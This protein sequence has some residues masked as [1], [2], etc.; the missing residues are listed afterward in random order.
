[1]K[2][3]KAPNLTDREDDVGEGV[4]VTTV[5][6][7][8]PQAFADEPAHPKAG[9]RRARAEQRSRNTNNTTNTSSWILPFG[10][11]MVLVLIGSYLLVSQHETNLVQH[12]KRNE[13]VHE[14]EMSQKFDVMYSD[15][16]KENSKLK[17]EI[18][19]YQELLQQNEKLIDEKKHFQSKQQNL[20]KQ[21]DYLT[22]YKKKMHDNIQLMS[23]TA[24]L[25]K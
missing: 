3:R 17:G 24:L 18:Q 13:Q 16:Q 14:H 9:I 8:L 1:M 10:I 21:V 15:L 2:Y 11:L 25:E 19:R 7:D 5:G 6:V 4:D 20:E 23:K 22:V 12:L